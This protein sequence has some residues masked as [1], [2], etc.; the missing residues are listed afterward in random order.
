MPLAPGRLFYVAT[1]EENTIQENQGG[2]FEVRNPDEACSYILG[3]GLFA[4]R[5]NPVSAV[6]VV[7][8]EAGYAFA[9]ADAKQ[10]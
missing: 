9:A 4:E 2:S 10:V 7:E 5:E 1:Y 6:A 8:A 3:E